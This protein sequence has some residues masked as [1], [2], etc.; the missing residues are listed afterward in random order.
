MSSC[1]LTTLDL[2]TGHALIRTEAPWPTSIV[3]LTFVQFQ[4]NPCSIQVV[5]FLAHLKMFKLHHL[6]GLLHNT[7]CIS[8]L[9]T[10]AH[11]AMKGCRAWPLHLSLPV[12]LQTRRFNYCSITE[13]HW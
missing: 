9:S 11:A 3:L 7:P 5:R 8:N 12:H 13:T 2:R 6:P 4:G 10:C 1:H